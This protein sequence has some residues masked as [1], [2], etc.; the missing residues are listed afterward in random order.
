LATRRLV[1]TSGP[2]GR[3]PW[4]VGM[5]A[6]P[7]GRKPYWGHVAPNPEDIQRNRDIEPEGERLRK[8]LVDW[9]QKNR[10]VSIMLDTPAHLVS[11]DIAKLPPRIK[12]ALTVWGSIYVEDSD[13]G[14]KPILG[15]RP[16]QPDA[17]Q[18]STESPNKKEP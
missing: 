6:F 16:E 18:P 3:S 10:I 11:I 17:Q 4:G 15:E 8:E 2:W 13:D 9:L 14:S 12:S 5:S 7:A 1:F